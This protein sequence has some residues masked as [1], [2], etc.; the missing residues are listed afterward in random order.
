MSGF[1]V[2][3]FIFGILIF[4]MG[5]YI[6]TGH[7]NFIGRGYFKKESRAYLRYMGKIV[8][9]L[10]LSPILCG[11]SLCIGNLEETI[12]PVIILIISF[13]IFIII[14]VTCFKKSI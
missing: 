1:A 12:I 9:L 2:L 3:M 7:D 14:G 11:I 8:M 4:L 13:I 5:I 10:A 6:Y